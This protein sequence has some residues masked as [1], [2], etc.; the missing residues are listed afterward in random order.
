[1]GGQVEIP[2]QVRGIN[3]VDHHIRHLLCQV[4]SDIEFLGRIT[5]QRVSTGQVSQ[6]ELIAEE[7][8]MGL[9]GVNSHTTVIS[10][11][12]VGAGSEVKQRGLATVGITHKRHIDGTT[13]L[14]GLMVDVVFLVDMVVVVNDK[15]GGLDRGIG[16]YHFYHFRLMVPQTYLIAHQLVLHGILQRCIQ[17]HLHLLA[18]DKAHLNDTL[19]EA[20]MPQHLDNDSFLACF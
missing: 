16:R 15:L 10:H 1:M 2:F 13:L 20:T 8:S 12:S 18:L 14:H 7:R 5:T 4:L 11:M 6:I 17:Q 9:C 3:D 19:A